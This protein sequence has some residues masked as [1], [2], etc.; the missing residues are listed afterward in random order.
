MVA[1][2]NLRHLRLHHAQRRVRMHD[3]HHSSS[4]GDD[5][6]YSFKPSLMGAGFEFRLRPDAL[7]WQAGRHE[8]RAPYGRIVRVRLSFRPITMQTRRVIAGVLP[9]GRPQLPIAPTTR[10]SLLLQAAPE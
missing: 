9:A 5:L 4:A 1:R 8:G 2:P 6:A 3:D 7:E 10:R